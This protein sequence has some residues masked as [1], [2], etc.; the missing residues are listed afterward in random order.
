MQFV[1]TTRESGRLQVMPEDQRNAMA[2]IADLYETLWHTG[3]YDDFFGNFKSPIEIS[4]S[5]EQDKV[6]FSWRWT[7]SAQMNSFTVEKRIGG[8]LNLCDLK[9][10]EARKS[11]AADFLKRFNDTCSE[12]QRP[13]IRSVKAV[14]LVIRSVDMGGT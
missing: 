14:D 4:F 2:F 1:I 3:V 11:A 6:I 12:F 7:I 5:E 8:R 10:D 9:S 13:E